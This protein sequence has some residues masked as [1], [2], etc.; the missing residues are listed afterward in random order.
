MA[1]A[2][3]QERVAHCSL[4]GSVH[5]I[6][7]ASPRADASISLPGCLEGNLRCCGWCANSNTPLLL[8]KA[9]HHLK[10]ATF[11]GRMARR[12]PY[13]IGL[14]TKSAACHSALQVL[15]DI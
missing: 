15:E 3:F 10:T 11:R 14:N 1:C 12:D 7:P 9:P 5:D 2:L 8:S 4:G 6:V 13:T